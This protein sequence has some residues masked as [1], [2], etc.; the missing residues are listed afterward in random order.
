MAAKTNSVFSHPLKPSEFHMAMELCMDTRKSLM[1]WG[2]PGIGKSMLTQQFADI[3][4]P[5][6]SQNMDLLEQLKF[7]AADKDMPTVTSQTVTDFEAKLLDQ[8][9]NLVDFRLSQVDPTDLRGI[10]V[11]VTFYRD[12]NTGEFVAD[13]VVTAAHNVE[14][15]TETFWAPP[16]ALNLP[17]DWKGIIFMDEV[18]GAMP[19]VQAACYQLFLDRKLGELVLPTD[20]MVMAAG[21]RENDGGVT[22]QLA[23]PLKDRMIHVELV[24]DLKEWTEN[25]AMNAR[26]HPDVI[27]Y[28]QI[29]TADFNTLSPKNPNIC[30]GSSPRSWV[31]GSET[32]YAFEKRYGAGTTKQNRVL[33][34]M[35]DGI[36][37]DDIAVRFKAHREMTCKL[38]PVM[39][40]LTGKFTDVNKIEGIDISKNYAICSNLVYAMLDFTKEKTR[41]ELEVDVYSGYADKFL[42]FLDGNYG[43]R[44]TELAMMAIK[45]IFNAKIFFNPHQVPFYREFAQKHHELIVA[46]RVI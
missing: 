3:H 23:T 25:Y 46:A 2:A 32:L 30:G 10:P 13:H 22:F 5:V 34:A 15:V 26:V 7:E 27:S 17:A 31:T 43:T 8:E 19:I 24:H 35:I 20:A 4:F 45:S 40:I 11:P 41:N 18:N 12:V 42:R 39:D 21:N 28:L 6:R 1:V 9:C 14:K 36:V 33:N 16:A 44:N 38:P 37:G 29:R